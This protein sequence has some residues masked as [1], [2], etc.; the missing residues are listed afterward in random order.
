MTIKEARIK[1][2]LTQKEMSEL[3]GIPK[4]N[5]ENWEADNKSNPT[6]WAEKL[7]VEELKR[8]TTGI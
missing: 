7:I 2:G 3:L 8:K 1:S 4:R 6:P 5:I